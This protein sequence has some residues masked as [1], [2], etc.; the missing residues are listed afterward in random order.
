MAVELIPC[1]ACGTRNAFHRTRCLSCGAN[2]QAGVAPG[3]QVTDAGEVASLEAHKLAPIEMWAQLRSRRFFAIGAVITVLVGVAVYW[4]WTRLPPYSF[5]QAKKAVERHDL[6]SFEKYVDVEG[7][8]SST[9]DQLIENSYK[10]RPEPN[11]PWS[12]L[13]ESMARGLVQLMKPRLVAAVKE[14]VVRF[15]EKGDFGPRKSDSDGPQVSLKEIGKKTVGEKSKFQGI[16]YVKKQGSIAILGLKFL[17]AQDN[18]AVILD[19][20]MRD[21]G[22]YW[23]IT[24]LSN[25]PEFLGKLDKPQE[26][27]VSET[28]TTQDQSTENGGKR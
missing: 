5:W 14:Q 27:R 26:G 22:G 9:V 21:R 2:I 1:N 17:N 12:K 8:A 18:A 28:E 20:K 4:Q 15:V 11:D 16:E 3:A 24:E 13:G 6:T 25:F 23:Q 7:L 19:M 10:Q